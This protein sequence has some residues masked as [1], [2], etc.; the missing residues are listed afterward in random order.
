MSNTRVAAVQ[1]A[2]GPNVSANLESAGKLLK[3]GGN[4]GLASDYVFYFGS[5]VGETGNNATTEV[6]VFDMLGARNNVADTGNA[7]V[8]NKFDFNRGHF[9][10][11]FTRRW[12]CSR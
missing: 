8:L 12:Y 2:S 9:L 10:R 5:A 11:S 1:M 4:V 7:D 6:D 3:A